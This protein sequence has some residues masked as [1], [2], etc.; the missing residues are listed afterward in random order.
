MKYASIQEWTSI[1]KNLATVCLS[2]LHLVP[3]GCHHPVLP[4]FLHYYEADG[5]EVLATLFLL[6][7][8]KLLKTIVTALSSTTI[9]VASAD[10]VSDLLTPQRVWVYDGSMEYGNSRHLPLLVMSLLFLLFLF[11]PSHFY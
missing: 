7:Y 6:S 5:N 11:F 4:L 10:N 9:L 2:L 1:K 8:A 3:G